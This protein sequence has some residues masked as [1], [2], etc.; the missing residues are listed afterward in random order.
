MAVLNSFG[1]A[2][3]LM[4]AG[5]IDTGRMLGPPFALDQFPQVLASVRNGEGVKIQVAPG[6]QPARTLSAPPRARSPPRP[7]PAPDP[8]AGVHG[9]AGRQRL[10]TPD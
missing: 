9:R 6:S 5:A 7:A 10:M 8:A 3:D 4:A 1:A 2:A